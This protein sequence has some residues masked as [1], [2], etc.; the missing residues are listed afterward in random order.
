MAVSL[1]V[2]SHRKRRH[3]IYSYRN[4]HAPVQKEIT[5]VA[6]EKMY[7]WRRQNVAEVIFIQVY[8]YLVNL[9]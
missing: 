8:V 6:L 2:V 5:N 9:P 7:R 3:D 4:Q 1:L